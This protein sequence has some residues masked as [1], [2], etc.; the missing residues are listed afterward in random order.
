MSQPLTVGSIAF[1]FFDADGNDGFAFVAVDAIA[2]G[3]V[4]Y[5]MDNEPTGPVTINLT[6]GIITWTAPAG[7]VAAGREVV[8]TGVAVAARSVSTGT[9]S[10]SGSFILANTDVSIFAFRG[11]SETT[12]TTYLF[13]ISNNAF[14]TQSSGSL[15]DTGLTAG[16]NA[17][18]LT[19]NVDV[20]RC[21]GPTDF[22]NSKSQTL[23]RVEALAAINDTTPVTGD[24]DT[25]T[26]AS[27]G[28]WITQGGTNPQN[29]D[30]IPP[31]SGDTPRLFEI[32]CFYPGTL[33]ATPVGARAV[34]APAIGDEV[35][36]STGFAAPVRWMG[37]QTVSTQFGDPL[38]VLPI[39]I[40]IHAG[41]LAVGIPARDLLV[42]PDHAMM[43]GDILIQAGALVNG[44]SIMRERA[45]PERFTYHHV[46]LASHVL[47]L[48][49]GAPAETFVDNVDRMTFDNCD[50]H[51]ALCGHLPSIPEMA[52][53][54]AKAH[55]QVPARLRACLDARAIA[56]AA[57][58]AA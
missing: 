3:T 21:V 19:D 25:P 46:E 22:N 2:A 36:T 49:E 17:V 56:I 30:G 51:Q 7:G 15:V 11:T 14:S 4:I 45:V 43:V 39:R 40:R 55:R 10:A 32:L 50:E 38:R 5:F 35:L 53:P 12:Q 42:S 57:Q 31:D 52:I 23:S 37:R 20:A 16:V 48:A 33:I 47:I 44:T 58:S 29:A 34:E 9:L 24:Q 6:E 28:F 13:A 1:T 8:F 41:T 26:Q 54:R 27:Q 18:A